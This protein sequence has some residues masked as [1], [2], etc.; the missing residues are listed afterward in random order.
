MNNNNNSNTNL[1][2]KLTLESAL[3]QSNS[4]L[5]IAD[6][7]DLN[8]GDYFITK[9]DYDP[10]ILQITN[11]EV[12]E[13]P[14]NGQKYVRFYVDFLS[15][16]FD[17][18]KLTVEKQYDI[19]DSQFKQ[20]YVNSS[21]FRTLEALQD[22]IKLANA[23]IAGEL[24][25][26]EKE[27]ISQSTALMHASS[28]S[29]LVSLQESIESKRQHL[30]IIRNLVEAKL[31]QEKN[32]L[33]VIRRN[34]ESQMAVFS[35]QIQVIM[36]TIQSIELY[37]GISEDLFQIQSGEPASADTKISFRQL[38]LFMDEEVGDAMYGGWDYKD[39]DRFDKWLITNDKYKELVPEEKCV[40]VFKPRRSQKRYSDNAYENAMLNQYNSTTY[41]LIRNGE[42]LYRIYS[43]NLAVYGKLF[44]KDSELQ[45]ILDKLNAEETHKSSFDKKSL[46]DKADKHIEQYSRQALLLQGLIDRSEVFYPLAIHD[47]NIFKLEQFGQYFNFVYDAENTLTAGRLSFRNWQK[48]I[49]EKIEYGSRIVVANAPQ[50]PKDDSQ[51]RYVRYYENSY[52]YPAPPQDG[53][54]TVEKYGEFRDT[55][56]NNGN[57]EWLKSE[58]DKHEKSG[59]WFEVK[60][61][62]SSKVIRYWKPM[63]SIKYTD[64]YK[65]DWRHYLDDRKINR[66]RY[67]IYNDDSFIL[68]YD[69]IDLADIDYYLTNRI[70][71][72]NYLSMMPVLHEIK[73][74][75]LAE[76]ESETLFAQ[77][78]MKE[79]NKSESEVLAAIDWWKFKNQWKRPIAQDDAKALRM[80]IKHLNKN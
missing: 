49:N 40:V 20:Y 78:V 9:S 17:T 7:N 74:L 48:I 36:K 63:L 14:S 13:I 29:T 5:T 68:N 57:E 46:Q 80:I 32:K 77:L 10:A 76:L 64:K 42:N 72:P 75:R 34:L 43:E 70:D 39:I 25:F 51:L 28:K 55:W 30:H 61:I 26:E 60:T 65:T 62:G 6:F 23:A 58:I 22:Y 2:N 16:D 53:L 54:Y 15:I 8:I 11:I 21:H 31:R 33:D 35:K 4:K 1:S 19:S 52:R 71:R 27:E 69:Q 3:A 37:L 45:D 67:K 12:N 59:N 38:I 50:A 79:S 41:L 18:L 24:N 56:I 73:K 66:T 44:P 47:I